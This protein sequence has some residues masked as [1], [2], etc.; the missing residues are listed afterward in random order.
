MDITKAEAV[1]DVFDV[2]DIGHISTDIS[3]LGPFNWLAEVVSTF[4]QEN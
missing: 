1:I 3:G 2:K 4:K